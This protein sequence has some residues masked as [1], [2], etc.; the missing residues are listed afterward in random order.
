MKKFSR[1]AR[2]PRGKENGWTE[3]HP[4]RTHHVQAGSRAERLRRAR[5]PR[6]EGRRMGLPGIRCSPAISR[7]VLQSPPSQGSHTSRSG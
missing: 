6:H 4:G 3:A 2:E 1:R 5:H 7:F